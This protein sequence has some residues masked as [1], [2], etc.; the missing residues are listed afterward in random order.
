MKVKHNIITALFNH[1]NS[2]S[3]LHIPYNAKLSRAVDF[4]NLP[5]NQFHEFNFYK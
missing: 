4:V 3:H 2:L 1:F 5:K